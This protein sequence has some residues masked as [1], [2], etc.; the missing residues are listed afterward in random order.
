MLTKNNIDRSELMNVLWEVQRKKRHL[1]HDDITKIAQE[2]GMSRMEL[3]G[4]ITFYHFFHR[5]DCGKYTIYV[6]DSI[7][8]RYSGGEAVLKAFEEAVG[9]KIGHV[10]A[11]KKFGLFKTPCIGL[12]DQEPAC[13]INFKPFTNLTPEKVQTI[14]SKLKDGAKPSEICDIP[15]SVIQY[16]PEADRTVFFKPYEKFSALEYIRKNDPE[17]LIELVKES[18]LTGRG[19]AF[20][21]TGLK[22]QYCRQN[23]SDVKYLFVMQTKESPG[24]LKIVF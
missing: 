22:W 19:G 11:D 8:A 24:H 18:K 2:F 15:K 10:T 9:V 20:F 13:L 14:I 17:W 1:G 21:P 5:T 6:N 12:S 23:E 16:T 3:E 7:I 4:V